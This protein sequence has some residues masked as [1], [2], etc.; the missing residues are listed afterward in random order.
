MPTITVTS[1]A[2]GEDYVLSNVVPITW[3]WTGL[4]IGNITLDYSNDNFTTRRIIATNLPNTG[5]YDWTVP[6][7]ALTGTTL[8]I[9]LRD[10]TRTQIVGMSSGYFRIRGGFVLLSPNGGEQWVSQSPQT[11]AWQTLG[12]IPNVKLEYSLDGTN[13]S[14]IA[15]PQNAGTY[16][17]TLPNAQTTEARVRISDPDDATTM[18]SSNAAFSMVYSTVV[19]KVLDYDSL[20]HLQDFAVSE[21]V[22]GWAD[23]GQN[24][25]ITRTRTY[26]YG[27]YTT[28]F[29]KQDFIDSSVT[30]NPPK[31]GNSAY[32]ITIYMENSANAQVAWDAILTYS[33]SPANDTLMAVG[34]LQRKGKLIGTTEFERLDLGAATLKIF[35]PDGATV[36]NELVATTPASTG[37]YNFTLTDT[38]FEGGLVYPATLTIEYRERPYVSVANIDVGSEILQY[39]F[40]TQ[41]AT[42]L[43]ASVENIERV[44]N[45]T[46]TDIKTEVIKNLPIFFGRIMSS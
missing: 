7:D 32:N 26:P 17:W 30:W 21:P 6:A 5:S 11:I 8:K 39:Q 3:T 22:T 23:S 1:P 12:T 46:S 37:M 14:F 42:N 16:A 18:D 36:R 40:F 24:S 27:S 25:P 35:E 20:Q 41:T 15:A 13:W 29:T 10:G 4:S 43:A 28:F 9:R 44:V 2:G 34:S 31:S 19:F 38:N 45:S 33:F